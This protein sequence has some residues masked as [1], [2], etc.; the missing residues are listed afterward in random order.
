MFYINNS[1]AWK[2]I[3]VLDFVI[4]YFDAVNAYDHSI[5]LVTRWWVISKQ[6]STLKGFLN[7]V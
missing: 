4:K 3:R 1:R 7:Q 6:I 2:Y 5:I